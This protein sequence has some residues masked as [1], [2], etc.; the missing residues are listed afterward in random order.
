VP[1]ALLYRA[2][3][4]PARE[5]E[6]LNFSRRREI[7]PSPNTRV[8]NRQ[9]TYVAVT[10]ISAKESSRLC[11]AVIAAKSIARNLRHTVSKRLK[12]I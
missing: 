3:V 12:P 7:W 6:R 2:W 5:G 1:L 4:L 9:V 10:G 8:T 11:A